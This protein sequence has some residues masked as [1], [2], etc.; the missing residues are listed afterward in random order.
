MAD[1]DKAIQKYLTDQVN[2]STDFF[3][4]QLVT[5]IPHSKLP[6][7]IFVNYFLPY[8]AGQKSVK[9]IENHIFSQWVGV[10]GSPTSEV[11]IIDSANRVLYSV[12]ALFD[13]N[14]FQIATRDKGNSIADIMSEYDLKN[15][16][17]PVVANRY[18]NETLN[19][20]F[21]EIKQDP[22]QNGDQRWNQIF[23]RYNIQTVDSP[24]GKEQNVDPSN[25][26]EYD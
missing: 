3:Y 20:K 25:D 18:L 14:I 17:L 7:D 23:Q 4:S 8:F 22:R 13:T 10:A 24:N 9:Q 19:R 21:D 15:N 11:D 16:V 6:E 2:E 5:S 26:L 12:P 1:A